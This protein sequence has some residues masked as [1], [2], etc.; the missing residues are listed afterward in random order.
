V[1]VVAE[2]A[3]DTIEPAPHAVQAVQG[4]MPVAE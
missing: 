2:H 1:S 3:A 4:S